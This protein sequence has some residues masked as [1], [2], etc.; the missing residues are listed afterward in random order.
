MTV[1][2][3]LLRHYRSIEE[4]IRRE[5]YRRISEIKDNPDIQRISSGAFIMP[6]SALSKDLILS[7]SYYDFHE[8]KTKLLEIVNSEKS[9]EKVIEKLRV[10]SEMGFIQVGSSGRGYKFR[11]HPRVCSNIKTMLNE[12]N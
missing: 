10:I 3:E 12:M 2:S 9:V 4:K 7:P 8:Q 1:F 11:F 6:V 5:L